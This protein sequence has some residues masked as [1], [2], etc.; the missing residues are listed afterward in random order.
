M[1]T[2]K[3]S[4]LAFFMATLVLLACTE[5]SPGQSGLA[6]QPSPEA[7]AKLIAQ[8][9]AEQF[10]TRQ[11]ASEELTKLGEPVLPALRRALTPKTEL[12]VKRRIELIVIRIKAAP[13]ENLVRAYCAKPDLARDRVEL[14]Q[15]ALAPEGRAF[16]YKLAATPVKKPQ[17]ALAER[18]AL[19]FVDPDTGNTYDMKPMPGDKTLFQRTFAIM[20]LMGV[21]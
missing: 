17:E 13:V 8:L 6:E 20:R 9:G 12:E 15:S 4:G 19:V 11:Q 5:A 14:W 2:G 18:Y 1:L 7:V 10:R 16:R 21:K 3:C